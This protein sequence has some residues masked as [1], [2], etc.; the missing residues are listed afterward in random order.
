VYFLLPNLNHIP[1]PLRYKPEDTHYAVP[2][3]LALSLSNLFSCMCS[4]RSSSKQNT[5]LHTR[6]KQVVKSCFVRSCT[7]RVCGEV[8]GL[9]FS[10]DIAG[11]Q[12]RVPQFEARALRKVQPRFRVTTTALLRKFLSSSELVLSS[13]LSRKELVAP[14]SINM[15]GRSLGE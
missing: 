3:D 14:N 8:P 15:L 9:T 13:T 11:R 5:T 4:L 7:I 6:I 2:S 1:R 10:H 12:K